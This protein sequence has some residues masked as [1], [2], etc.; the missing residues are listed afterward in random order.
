MTET[1]KIAS[2]QIIKFIKNNNNC[3]TKDEL[4]Q[5]FNNLEQRDFFVIYNSLKDDFHL[6]RFDNN[7]FSLTK[8]GFSF[9][10]F[11]EM[12][13]DILLQKE[14][15]NIEYEKNKIDLELSKKILAEYPKTKWFARIAFFIALGLA[16]LE[17]IKLFIKK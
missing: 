11:E 9:L 2:Q 17:L 4:L 7:A 16:M 12:E 15:E 5:K 13:K 6:I 14:K 10:S 8:E 1:Q 3:V